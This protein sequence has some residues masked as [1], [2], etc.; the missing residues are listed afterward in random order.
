MNEVQQLWEHIKKDEAVLLATSA[1][2]NVS[3]RVVSPVYY[4]DA[5]LIFTSP[6]STKYQQLKAN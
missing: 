3:M 1:G 4:N 6:A 2:G 5:I